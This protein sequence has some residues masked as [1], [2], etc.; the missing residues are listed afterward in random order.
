MAAI[1]HYGRP[2]SIVNV[3]Q[4]CQNSRH[5]R[6]FDGRPRKSRSMEGQRGERHGPA[7]LLPPRPAVLDLPSP[8]KSRIYAARCI[9]CPREHLTCPPPSDCWPPLVKTPEPFV[10]RMA[11]KRIS[12]AHGIL[13][14]KPPPHAYVTFARYLSHR[15]PMPMSPPRDAHLTTATYPCQ[16]RSM[17]MSS[18]PHAHVTLATCLCH[19]GEMPMSPPA[20]CLCRR[21]EM[22]MSP[23]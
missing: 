4:S 13:C 15:H 5:A 1:V 11:S 9:A 6:H 22:P 7:R 17:P 10:G 16:L 8:K 19:F 21:S 3:D 14:N 18:W 2:Q 12:L 20:T 23:K